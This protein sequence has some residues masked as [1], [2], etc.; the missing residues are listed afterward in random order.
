MPG[1]QLQHLLRFD[2]F[3]VDLRTGELRKQGF[4]LRL[5]GQPMQVLSIL[6]QN[7]G[8][9]LTREELRAQIWPAD[10][11]VDFDHS[12]NNAIRRIRE[13]LEDS[14]EAPRYVE[15]LPRRGYRFIALVEEVKSASDSAPLVRTLT[16]PTGQIQAIAVLPLEDHS[17][18]DVGDYFADGMTEALITSL[19]KIKALRVISRTSIMQY[20]GVR[21]SLPQIARELKVDVVIEGSVLRSGE[22]VR[23]AVQ[24]IDARADQ[25]LWAENYERDFRD[26][27]SLQSEIARQVANEV[28]VIL[29][30]EER[31]RLETTREV[32]P[33]AHELYLQA[34]HFWNKRTE[35]S[36]KKALACFYAAIDKDP[37]FAQGYAGLADCYNILGYYNALRPIEA[38]PVA[39]AAAEKALMLDASLGEA[40]ASL[41]V[42]KRDYEWDWA[43]AEEEFG[44]AIELSPGYVASYHWRSTLFTML[45]Q[46][47]RGIREKTKALEIDPLS[48]IIR[49]DLARMFYFAREYE[50]SVEHYRAAI[51]LSPDFFLARIGLAHALEQMGRFEDAITELKKGMALSNRG[52]Y[53][54][55]RLGH[56]YG[57]A[58]KVENAREVLKELSWISEQRYV[59]AYDLALVHL[60]LREIEAALSFLERAFEQRS[61]WM[62]Y[63]KVEPHLDP[64]RG[65]DRFKKLLTT[66]RL[67]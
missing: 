39:K 61:L 26:I 14:A 41:G 5:Q 6:L 25:H 36:V 57:L 59:S 32:D 43:G 63:L 10:T 44:R 27:L 11:F 34:R 53:A 58:G 8:N 31:E 28:R 46:H 55:A 60:G 49:T 42:V 48:A 24:L 54:L 47:E 56:G 13:V 30:P 33:D 4:K 64:L 2:K 29:S 51:E 20:K 52:V 18:G 15:T 19:A 7:A 45:G 16:S 1:P 12:L 17:G 37:G 50:T 40:H 3:E 38:Y 23:I 66:L 9:V 65:E 22:R 21:K 62:G 67:K 35:E